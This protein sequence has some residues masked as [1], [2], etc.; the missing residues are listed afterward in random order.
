M[1]KAFKF[2]WIYC[3]CLFNY[4]VYLHK[5]A[6]IPKNEHELE[7]CVPSKYKFESA[8]ARLGRHEILFHF[9]CILQIAFRP[10]NNQYQ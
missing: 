7:P 2:D 8:L 1:R 10:F 9:Q 4:S 5:A 3:I 6:M